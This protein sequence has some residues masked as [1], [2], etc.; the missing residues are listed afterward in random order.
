[1]RGFD[2]GTQSG[3]ATWS[4]QVD[5]PL[6]RGV[7]QPVLFADA[8]QAAAASDLS[9]ARLLAGGGLGFALLSG[10]LRFDFSHPITTG[11]SGLRLDIG[12]RALW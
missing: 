5:W 4:V 9:G 11:G 10:V 12:A 1:M 2:Y 3:Q 6:I 7:L 8:G